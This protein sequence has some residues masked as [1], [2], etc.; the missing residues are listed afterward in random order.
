MVTNSSIIA[1]VQQ[2]AIDE[3]DAII[4]NFR[5]ENK[6]TVVILSGGHCDFFEKHLKNKKKTVKFDPKTIK[7]DPKNIKFN[8]KTIKFD[9]KMIKFE[10]KAQI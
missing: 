2:G 1:G 3:M 8:P 6:D 5:E 4:S 9:P 7:C 10:P